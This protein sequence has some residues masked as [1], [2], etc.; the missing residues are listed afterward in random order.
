MTP[1]GMLLRPA[2]PSA[3]LFGIESTYGPHAN[4]KI[5]LRELPDAGSFRVTVRAAKYDD[6]LL[7]DPG[8]PTQSDQPGIAIAVTNAS[9]PRAGPCHVLA[10]RDRHGM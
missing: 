2:I 3:E 7:L 9:E 1:E 6:G 8:A 5:S 4:F 10:C